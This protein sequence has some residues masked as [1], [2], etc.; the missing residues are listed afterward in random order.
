MPWT[1]NI[2]IPDQRS[3]DTPALAEW[4]GLL[5]LVHHLTA[6]V[7]VPVAVA[8]HALEAVRSNR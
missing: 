5:H 1:P 8:A 7:S 3:K 6:V 2:P 4:G